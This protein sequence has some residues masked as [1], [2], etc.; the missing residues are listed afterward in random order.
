MNAHMND[1][2]IHFN[3]DEKQNIDN[4]G[5][6]ISIVGLSA[7]TCSSEKITN[8]EWEYAILDASMA[9]ISWYKT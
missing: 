8:L 4:I 9:Y 5:K 1:A 2:S 6:L 3:P 7:F